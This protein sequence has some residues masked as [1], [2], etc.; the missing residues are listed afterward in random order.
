MI[1]MNESDFTKNLLYQWLIKI[2]DCFSLMLFFNFECVTIYHKFKYGIC[3]F[4]FLHYCV[5][6]SRCANSHIFPFCFNVSTFWNRLLIY[7]KCL[8]GFAGKK[9]ISW[10]ACKILPLKF[11]RITTEIKCYFQPF[12]AMNTMNKKGKKEEKKRR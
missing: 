9:R 12:L 5:F 2:A 3:F 1:W 8:N 4:F 6:L 7:T 11:N 10:V